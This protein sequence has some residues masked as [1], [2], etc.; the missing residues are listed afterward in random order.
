MGLR[1]PEQYLASLRDG[2]QVFYRGE[3][4]ADV[5]THP[6]LGR[7][8]QHLTVDFR[9]AEDPAVRPLAVTD[10][11]E[12]GRPV[13]RYFCIP[14][15]P[16]DLQ[17]R[18]RLITTVTRAAWS[19]VPLIKE[20]GTDALFALTVV[21]A[22]MDRELGTQFLPRVR[23]FHRHCR[24]GDLAMAVAQTDVK[25]DRARRPSEQPHPDLYVRVVERRRDGIVVRGAKAHTTNAVFSNE[26]VVLPTR[27]LGEAD[28]DYAVAFAIP[29]DTPGLTMVASPRGFGAT[30]EFDNPL[31]SRYSLTESLTIFDNVFVPTDRVFLDG[32][33][34]FAGQLARTFVEFHRFTAIAYKPPLL[35]LLLGAAALAA[36]AN[37][38]AGAPHVRDKLARLAM[39]LHTVTGLTT[40]AATA[41]RVRDGVAVPD[42][43]LTNVAKYHFARGYHEAVRDVQDIAGG[44]VVT[45]PSEDDWRNPAVRR[46]VEP[47]LQGRSGWDGEQRLRLMNLV[48]DLCASDLGGYL[49]VLAIHAEGSLETQK[50]TILADA[51]LEDAAAYAA[52]AAR[53]RFPVH[54]P[55]GNRGPGA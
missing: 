23:A 12:D 22:A 7:G 38:I 9:L 40:A 46:L 24:D 51:N 15:S 31:S 21:T 20:I 30:S 1:S 37:G 44:L 18:S 43:V 10:D 6:H 2:R 34:Q 19:F 29:A 42:V 39:Y 55:A 36:D 33:W 48:R 54:P 41:C 32:Q 26:I 5:T 14:R 3:A 25:G 13:S 27:A 52:A 16:H 47:Y 45:G 4:V 28:A 35:E 8:A 49:E 50:L 11:P 53:L 17:L